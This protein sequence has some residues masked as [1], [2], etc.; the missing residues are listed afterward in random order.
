MAEVIQADREIAA[1]IW[2]DFV[3]RA[4]ECIAENAIRSGGMDDGALVQ[5]FAAH[6]I[7]GQAD[8]ASEVQRLHSLAK[9]NNDLA[10]RYAEQIQS[11]R[12]AA[13]LA[14]EFIEEI[15]DEEGHSRSTAIPAQA[16]RQ[17]LS[18]AA[19][20]DTEMQATLRNLAGQAGALGAF[21]HEIRAI[22]GNTNWQCL[23]EARA[24]ATAALQPL[25]QAGE[26]A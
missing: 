25:S 18:G 14:L 26:D 10:R 2:R 8:L 7:A 16:I 5:A 22:A 6:R 15:Q 11:L 23:R 24:A 19:H 3:A 4:G 21:E 13:V 1:D 17:A 12:R 20:V 9:A